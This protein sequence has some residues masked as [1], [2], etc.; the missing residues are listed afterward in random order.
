[1]EDFE[2]VAHQLIYDGIEAIDHRLDGNFPV[3]EEHLV[4]PSAV[5]LGAVDCSFTAS[6]SAFSDSTARTFSI[7][8]SR[9]SDVQKPTISR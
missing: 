9:Y 3:V 7:F 1:M 2:I 4:C 6:T 5:L 8:F